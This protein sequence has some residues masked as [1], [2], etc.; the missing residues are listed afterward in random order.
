MDLPL[1]LILDLV[2]T[3]LLFATLVYCFVLNRR[4]SRLRNAKGDMAEMVR[5]F[6]LATEAARGSV[7]ELKSTAE[8]MAKD[9]QTQIQ[10]GRDMLEEMSVVTSSA[11]R[12][13]DRIEKGV[14]KSRP[15]AAAAAGTGA[16]REERPAPPTAA[17]RSEAENELLQ[18]LRK[19]R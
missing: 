6:H 1:D 7:D 19:V 11:G 3:G 9:L 16:M 12:L 18:A 17:P 10:H 14:E 15:A 5:S 13:A 8:A 2:L 4:L